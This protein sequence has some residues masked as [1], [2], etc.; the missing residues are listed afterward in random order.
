MPAKLIM[1]EGPEPGAEFPIQDEVL[2]IG[3]DRNCGYCLS[4]SGLAPHAFTLEYRNG[5][6]H[7]HNR[8]GDSIEVHGRRLEHR[9][10]ARWPFGEEIELGPGLSVRLDVHGD[11][12]PSK[13]AVAY[14]IEYDAEEEAEGVDAAGREAAAKSA[15]SKT[16]LQIIVILVCA[17]LGIFALMFDPG[18]VS[19]S[20][21]DP[22]VEFEKII[23]KLD[24]NAVDKARGPYSIKNSLQQARYLEARGAVEAKKAYAVVRDML[25]KH[26]KDGTLT[27]DE[28]EIWDFVTGRI[29]SIKRQPSSPL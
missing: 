14:T 16:M 21:K 27:E 24:N 4:D 1:T 7:L 12:A 6:Y 29:E 11:P 15:S 8:T 9:D 19:I 13:S 25:L 20:K 28:R 2:R 22:K 10:S 18:A 26:S 23:G 3:S 17:A 5:E